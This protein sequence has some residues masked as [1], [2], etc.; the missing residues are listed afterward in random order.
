PPLQREKR[1]I[2]RSPDEWTEAMQRPP[3]RDRRQDENSRGSF[4]LCKAEGCPNHNRSANESDWIISGG[5]G[6]PSAKD[7]PAQQDQQQEERTD[8]CG[9]LFV[10][11]PFCGNARQDSYGR[12][13]KSASRI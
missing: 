2:F 4:A 3:H 12:E 5:N 11:T 6:K 1:L 10:P 7:H 9:F 8:F 13:N